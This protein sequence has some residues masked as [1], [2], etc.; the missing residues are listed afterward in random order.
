[1]TD[2]LERHGVR[3]RLRGLPI[4]DDDDIIV[5]VVDE[6]EWEWGALTEGQQAIIRRGALKLQ[7]KRSLSWDEAFYFML[8]EYGVRCPHQWENQEPTFRECR[9]CRVMEPLPGRIVR[10]AGQTIRVAE[11]PPPILRIPVPTRLTIAA[12]EPSI[13]P[14]GLLVEEWRWTGDRY[15]PA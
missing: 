11:P 5:D 15:T 9:R 6:P 14:D 10:V 2:D 8:G 4:Y 7:T 1:M 13:L 3:F 12:Q